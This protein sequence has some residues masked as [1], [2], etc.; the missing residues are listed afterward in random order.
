M[1]ITLSK[2]FRHDTFNSWGSTN[3]LQ[4]RSSIPQLHHQTQ[5]RKKTLDFQGNTWH[6]YN[7]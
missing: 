1:S 6:A 4:T 5:L 3:T 2:F 7:T